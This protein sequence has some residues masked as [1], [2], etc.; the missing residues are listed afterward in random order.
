[1]RTVGL[2]LML[3]VA[4]HSFGCSDEA[5]KARRE[6]ASPEIQ[7]PFQDPYID[8]MTSRL[9]AM[10]VLT[11]VGTLEP[12]P[13]DQ[14]TA[15]AL[16]LTL[17]QLK[18]LNGALSE[19]NAAVGRGEF[20]VSPDLENVS[21][22]L[23]LVALGFWDCL[24]KVI[25]C[26]AYTT[27]CAF[28]VGGCIDGCGLVCAGTLGLGCVYCILLVCVDVAVPACYDALNCWVEY[29]QSGAC[30]PQGRKGKPTEEVP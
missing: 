3:V 30:F 25:E 19:I 8:V 10:L 13:V 24:K 22:P 29:Y 14:A 7:Y 15:E 23:M 17:D 28:A 11:D 26:S 6:I 2:G 20:V 16:D 5:D 18:T 1:M 21:R 4:M 12:L 27:T 9:E